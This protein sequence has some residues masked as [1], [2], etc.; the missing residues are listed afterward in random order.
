MDMNP[1]TTLIPRPTVPVAGKQMDFVPGFGERVRDLLYSN[2]PGV[3]A[4]PDRQY[5]HPS[6]S[7]EGRSHHQRYPARD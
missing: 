7:E 3:L 4:I 6:E 2:I 5:F 1:S